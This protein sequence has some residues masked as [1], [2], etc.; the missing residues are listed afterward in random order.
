MLPGYTSWVSRS[1]PGL[2]EKSPSP[3]G[4]KEIEERVG[5]LG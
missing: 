1:S 3:E 2:V 5:Y 4:G